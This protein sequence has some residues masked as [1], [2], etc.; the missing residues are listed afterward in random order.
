MNK[1][2]RKH[3]VIVGGGFGGIT[4]AKK[5]KAS[6]ADIT[7]I[8][9]S[10]HHLF[11]PLLYQVATAAL[12][13]GDISA[14]IRAIVGK[15][16]GLRVILGEVEKVLA[17]EKKLLIN[18]DR[19]VSYDELILAPGSQYNYFGNDDWKKDAPGLKSIPDAL[20]IRERILLSL[21]EA[22]QIDDPKLRSPT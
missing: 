11:Q 15:K 10:N 21:E 3:I 16:P 4:A 19:A 13:P 17:D 6:D 9:R 18:K 12:S 5:L 20:N 1:K 22:E 14:P 7:I 2:N 8:D